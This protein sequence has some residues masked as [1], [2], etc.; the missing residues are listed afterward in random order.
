MD[1]QCVVLGGPA[2]EGKKRDWFVPVDEPCSGGGNHEESSLSCPWN[3]R[4][5]GNR[6]FLR[7]RRF[8]GNCVLKVAQIPCDSTDC[9]ILMGV[10][11]TLFVPDR[12]RR[13]SA[14][15]Q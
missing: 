8:L 1:A 4:M 11:G 3:L 15:S 14:G 9:A 5:Q 7:N 13:A 12:R 6:R 10:A 2:E